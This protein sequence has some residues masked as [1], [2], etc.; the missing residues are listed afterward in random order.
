MQIKLKNTPEQIELI[1][2][3][4]SKNAT[5]A[6][7]ATEAVATFL[8]PVIRQVLET[9]GTAAQIYRD[10]EFDEDSDPSIPLD[11]FFD[12]GTG[13]VTVWSQHMAG[14]LP[15]SQ[16]EGVKELKFSTYRL[17]S[18][19]SFNKKYA[20]KS[21]LDVVSKS[22]ERMVQEV[23]IK[24]EKNAWAVVLKA[25]AEA[26]TRTVNTGLLQHV[27]AGGN[28]GQFVLNDLNNL[29]IRIKRINES[30]SGNTATQPFS[31]GITDLYVSPEV[32]ALIRAFAYNPINTTASASGNRAGQDQW[33]TE[34]LRNEI[35][36]NG[37]M[38]SIFGINIVEMIEFGLNQKYN[39]LF[40]SFAG[41]NSQGNLPAPGGSWSTTVNQILVGID[42]TRGSFLRPVARQAESGGTFNVLPDGQFD[43]YGSRVEK[44]GFYGFLEEGRV[45]LDARAIA[46]IAI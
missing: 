40:G 30:F 13:Y 17:D 12:Q 14:G 6:R 43:M 5:V 4:G 2:A 23:L 29:M 38:Q 26:W 42:N 7:E 9:A 32:K 10:I 28:A 11:L 20:R 37:G 21:R 33:I 31:T 36:Q 34:N 3:M 18:A 1:K 16:T 24:Q 22:I 25:L 19:V 8:G 27:I 39:T 15:T 41:G 35:Y 44:I 45:C 46:G